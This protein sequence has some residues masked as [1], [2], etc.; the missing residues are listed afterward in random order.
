MVV[1]GSLLEDWNATDDGMMS[2]YGQAEEVT[3]GN[4]E[5][6]GNE[7]S[8]EGE[9]EDDG[10]EDDGDEENDGDEDDVDDNDGD[11]DE[12]DDSTGSDSGDEKNESEEE[13]E[14]ENLDEGIHG[15][16]LGGGHTLEKG[17]PNI[18]VTKTVTKDPTS[19]EDT[20]KKKHIVFDEDEDFE[21]LPIPDSLVASSKSHSYEPEDSDSD[22]APDE[23]SIAMGKMQADSEENKK[24]KE[25][26]RLK[27]QTKEAR[28]RK[29]ERN[30]LQ[31]AAK[32][33]R[34]AK[35]STKR[36]SDNLLK[37]VIAEQKLNP[38][39]KAATQKNERK[40]KTFEDNENISN[41]GP[42]DETI[43][44]EMITLQR[45][46]K[47]RTLKQ[48]TKKNL[49]IAEKAAEFKRRVLYDGKIKRIESKDLRQIDVKQEKSGKK[50][51]PS[52]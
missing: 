26:M 9:E 32:R 51:I 47:V 14:D 30:E 5:E 37:A 6:L 7:S 46:I 39:Q 49:S 33:K 16:K 27:Q 31:Q 25:I 41:D 52:K 28:K 8:S 19:K 3:F 24:R 34:L 2:L 4:S 22:A 43:D 15:E 20:L 38:K 23:A 48:E 13:S 29:Q 21:N 50:Y 1:S 42:V 17:K 10:D 36:L 44:K 40:I 12:D 18:K 45:G 35:Q 11:D